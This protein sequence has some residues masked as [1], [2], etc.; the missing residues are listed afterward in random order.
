MYVESSQK[1]V[2]S[3]TV[4]IELRDLNKTIESHQRNSFLL[5]CL[6]SLQLTFTANI[7]DWVP[8]GILPSINN[9]HFKERRT[10]LTY[11]LPLLYQWL[12]INRYKIASE[13]DMQT[14]CFS[15]EIASELDMQM[16]CFSFLTYWN[17]L[18]RN[19][20]RLNENTWSGCSNYK[21]RAN[22]TKGI[23]RNNNKYLI[24]KRKEHVFSWVSEK[25]S[26]LL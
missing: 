10:L 17:N 4:F 7:D 5:P 6:H 9:K 19:V 11:I 3:E 25:N 24:W 14:I 1:D 13:F 8:L 12:S 15:Y 22:K 20:G 18:K 21:G 16:I 23:T 2:I 26:K